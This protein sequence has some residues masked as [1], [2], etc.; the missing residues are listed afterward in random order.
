V[1]SVKKD[2]PGVSVI[3]EY[4]LDVDLPQDNFDVVMSFQ[5]LEHVVSPRLVLE[6]VFRVLKKGGAYGHSVGQSLAFAYA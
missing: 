3:E 5:V 4:F 2:L 6:K 1:E